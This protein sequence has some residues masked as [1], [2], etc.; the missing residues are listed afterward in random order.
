MTEIP[1][2]HRAI[3]EQFLKL[4]YELFL[5]AQDSKIAESQLYHQ[6]IFEYE[7]TSRTIPEIEKIASAIVG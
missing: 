2:R 5:V 6:S 3:C 1:E 4:N 7:P